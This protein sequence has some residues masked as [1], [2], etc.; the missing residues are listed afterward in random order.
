MKNG[1]DY[2]GYA[3][4]SFPL[5]SNSV[6][7]SGESSITTIKFV[8]NTKPPFR[9]KI[10]TFGALIMQKPIVKP[11]GGIIAPAVIR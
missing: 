11:T 2:T 1:G 5:I 9:I 8:R 6:P 7:S 10:W 4:V 3:S